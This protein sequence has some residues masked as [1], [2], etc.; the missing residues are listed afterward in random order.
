MRDSNTE[1]NAHG[2]KYDGVQSMLIRFA[3]GICWIVISLN[4]FIYIDCLLLLV[5]YGLVYRWRVFET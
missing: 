1:Q 4:Y 5:L 3:P 2:R